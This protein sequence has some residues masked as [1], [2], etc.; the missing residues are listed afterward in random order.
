MKNNSELQISLEIPETIADFLERGGVK[1]PSV[2]NE[3]MDI[4]IAIRKMNTNGF[5]QV[6]VCSSEGKL[7]GYLS[8][9]CVFRGVC[10]SE[11]TFSG[12]VADYYCTSLDDKI[13]S[14][15]APVR[16]ALARIQTSE[17]LI[18]VDSIS[19]LHVKGL[20]TVSDLSALY[21]VILQGFT[22][23]GDIE[24][25]LKAIIASADIQI[26]ELQKLSRNENIKTAIDLTMGNLSYIMNNDRIWARLSISKSLDMSS[27]HELTSKVTG[28]RNRIMH[29][30]WLTSDE[31]NVHDDIRTLED[32]LSLL[33]A[34]M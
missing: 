16:D 19:E 20:I 18:I 26:I 31:V 8:W 7:Q 28:I 6:P 1:N 23:I 9:D 4:L 13:I 33:S 10:K 25:H 2:F 34:N 14:L 27:F 22:L 3:G 17:F 12:V 11:A 15:D 5:S 30:N 24:A 21:S 29:N 32:F